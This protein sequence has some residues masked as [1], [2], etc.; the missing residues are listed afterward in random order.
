MALSDVS[1]SGPTVY[2]IHAN[3]S[4]IILLGT[5]SIILPPIIVSKI[6]Y[7][8]VFVPKIPLTKE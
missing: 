6:S 1:A 8:Q 4:T 3:A 2:D 7:R 5:S